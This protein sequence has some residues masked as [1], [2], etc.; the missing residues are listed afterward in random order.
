MTAP[1]D[2][3]ELA[4]ASL[5]FD[6]RKGGFLASFGPKGTG[7]SELSYRLFA[8][9]PYDA[10]LLDVTGDV[11]PQHKL[12]EPLPRPLLEAA[13]TL[14]DYLA[15]LDDGGASLEDPAAVAELTGRVHAAWHDDATNRPRRYR[16]VPNL[17]R[18]DWLTR[19]DA[20][21]GL[22]YLHGRCC[23]F[24]DEIGVIA[25]AGRTPPFMRAVLHMGRHRALSMLMPGPR[26]AGLDPLVLG[27]ADVVTIHGQLH[28]LDVRRLAEHLHLRD[29][30]L[31]RLLEGLQRYR[32]DGIEVGQFLAYFKVNRELVIFEPLPPRPK[33]LA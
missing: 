1:V 7:K 14:L 8:S 26:P 31:G 16:Y 22:A 32:R 6:A 18:K 25:P 21:L 2:D 13:G 27:Q 30:E 4:E 33:R 12:T 20:V 11:D 19:L 5:R 9:Y 23:V 17:L 28:E 3:D 29:A 15:Q 24:A 10:L